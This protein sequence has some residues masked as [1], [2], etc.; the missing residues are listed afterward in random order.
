MSSDLTQEPWL[1]KLYDW[2]N[3]TTANEQNCKL[4][5]EKLKILKFVR[6]DIVNRWNEEF[7]QV[8]SYQE[9]KIDN[10]APKNEILTFLLIF[11]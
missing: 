7:R 1:T 5:C 6:A 11:A 2:Q 8:E 10:L 4:A 3:D 9:K